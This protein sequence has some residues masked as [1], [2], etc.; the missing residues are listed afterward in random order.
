MKII[1]L[2]A[3]LMSS[4][5]GLKQDMQAPKPIE[6]FAQSKSA[7]Y[8]TTM[9]GYE[10]VFHFPNKWGMGEQTILSNDQSKFSLFPNKG[11][12]GCTIS[13]DYCK[14]N[15][16]LKN[17]IKSLEK[18]F[19]NSHQI[20][21][22]FEASIKEGFFLC[23]EEGSF[24]VQMWYVTPKQKENILIWE[25]LKQCLTIIDPQVAAAAKRGERRV[26][27]EP[28]RGWW[29][30]HPA[31]SFDVLFEI[32]PTSQ[33]KA[34][35]GGTRN[36]HLQFTDPKTSGFFYVKWNCALDNA[37]TYKDHLK[38]MEAEITN[39]D[40]TQKSAAQPI[41]DLNNRY[42]TL[43]GSPYQFITLAGEDFLFGFAVKTNSP[44]LK[45]NLDDLS[46]RVKWRVKE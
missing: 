35:L 2:L 46:A 37:K 34:N 12:L 39:L 21:N 1:V 17:S 13:L 44:H 43:S 4:L 36:Y 18:L 42:A 45:T 29:C 32:P 30:H 3:Y 41:I 38:L 14:D 20:Q 19:P 24:L 15:A 25:G 6:G 23:K 28:M 10:I 9:N 40:S 22:G 16:A 8:K 31:S 26:T 5:F 11:G 27:E 33:A 7:S